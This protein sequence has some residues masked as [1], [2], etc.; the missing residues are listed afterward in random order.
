MAIKA[1]AVSLA[2]HIRWII[3]TSLGKGKFA[4]KW[5]FSKVTPLLK[6]KDS[7]RLDP[8]AYIPVSM[9]P[10]LSKLVEWAA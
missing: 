3:N 1:A 10:T 5:K 8:A 2:N 4:N 9:L 6:S 7:D